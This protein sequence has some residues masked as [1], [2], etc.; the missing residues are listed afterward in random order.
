MHTWDPDRYLTYGDERGRPFADLIARIGAVN[1]RTVVD[2]GCGPG[3]LTRLLAERWPAAEVTGW[4]S[5]PKMVERARQLGVDARLGDL[6][7][8]ASPAA[9]E[10]SARVDAL[11]SNATLQWLPEHLDLVGTLVA[12]VSPGG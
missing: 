2:L 1:P 10:Q 9:G 4:D 7:D 11:I 6:R 8:W 12:R 5:S 3:N